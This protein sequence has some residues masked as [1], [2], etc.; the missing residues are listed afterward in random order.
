MRPTM[1]AI[2]ADSLYTSETECVSGV[3]Q[4][5]THC[6]EVCLEPHHGHLNSLSNDIVA[7]EVDSFGLSC[8][9]C[10]VCLREIGDG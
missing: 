4:T 2:V 3:P 8:L 1:R 5:S 9:Q 10:T 7:A 6:S